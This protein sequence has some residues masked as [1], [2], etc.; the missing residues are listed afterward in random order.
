MVVG[1]DRIGA[2]RAVDVALRAV[3]GCDRNLA[4]DI[5]QRQAFGDQFCRIDLDADRRLLLTPDH[6]LRH[7]GNLADLLRELRVDGITDRG[8]RQRLGCRRQQQ[9]RRIRRIDLA[10]GRRRGKI[11]RQLAAGGIDGA[12]HIVGGAIDTAVEVELD[13]DRRCPEIARRGHLGDAGNLREL[14]LERLRHRG[15]H[16]FGAGAGEVRG[17]LDGREIHLRQRRHRQ[18]R[19]SD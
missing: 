9:D 19:I 15:G 12:L 10:I 17:D 14:P 8:Q 1:V 11:F 16:G 5:F 18:Q 7:A 2:R 3:D 13:R 6:Y 4:A